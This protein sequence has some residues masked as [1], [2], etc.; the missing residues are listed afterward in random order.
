MNEP[1]TEQDRA[2][3]KPLLDR[4]AAVTGR[5]QRVEHWAPNKRYTL[6]AE[7][8]NTDLVVG[9]LG[10]AGFALLNTFSFIE[11]QSVI[12]RGV[13]FQ[14]EEVE[15]IYSIIGTAAATGT[16]ATIPLAPPDRGNFVDFYVKLHD[17]GSDR[18]WQND[19]VPGNFFASANLGGLVFGDE[20]HILVSGGSTVNASVQAARAQDGILSNLG[21]TAVN[22]HRFQISLIGCQ[23]P[24]EGA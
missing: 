16:A 9:N 22:T 15:V 24:L 5:K 1:L 17:S 11:A 20:A 8:A 2:R 6:V 21:F 7:I 10:S 18:D 23:V 12:D 14:C 13:V 4:L 3:L 19:W